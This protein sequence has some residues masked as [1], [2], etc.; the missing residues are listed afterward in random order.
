VGK[1]VELATLVLLAT[2]VPRALGPSDF[3]QF[4]VAL[5]MVTLGSLLLTLGS[6]TLMA[7]VVPR[8]PAH[9]RVGL[10][11]ALGRRLAVER[12]IPV[13]V[14]GFVVLAVA[15]WDPSIVTPL[16]VGLVFAAFALNVAT[17]LALQVALGLGRTGPWSARWPLQNATLV[18]AVLV[19][20]PFAGVTG[21]LVAILLAALVGAAFAA[22]V[23]MRVAGGVHPRVEIPPGTMKFGA[24]LA[25]GAAFAQFAQ[26]GGV[27]AVALLGTSTRQVGYTALAIGIAL[28]VTYAVLQSFTVALPHLVAPA[29]DGKAPDAAEA[30]LRRLASAALVVLLPAAALLAV[31]LDF[32]VPALFGDDFRGASAAFGPALAL[33]VLAPVGSLLT[34]AAALRDRP[35]AELASAALGAL[36]FVVAALVAVPLWDAAGGTAAVLA[37]AAVAVI[38]EARMLPRATGGAVTAASLVGAA[39]VLALSFT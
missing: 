21:T 13:T 19:V 10:A 5:T 20:H 38:T 28:G 27:L 7:R 23:L 39:V 11:R 17:S 24:L 30:A 18:A 14:L 12:A 37:G 36:A 34:Q 31:S 35:H 33:L 8:A 29:S 3:G 1:A 26:R 6:P 15:L 4:S 25:G 9:E 22:V 2:V 16:D 32:L